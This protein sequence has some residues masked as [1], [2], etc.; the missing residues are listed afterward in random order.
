[1]SN[2]TAKLLCIYLRIYR[3]TCV[4][5]TS[6][7]GSMYML[8]VYCILYCTHIYTLYLSFSRR[9]IFKNVVFAAAAPEN[10][11]QLFDNYVYTIDGVYSYIRHSL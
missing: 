7:L 6:N 10:N 5:G 2:V 3:E 4:Q 11:N 8:Y 1:M 9:M